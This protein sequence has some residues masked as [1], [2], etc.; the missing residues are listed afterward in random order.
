MQESTVD[1]AAIQQDLGVG[2]LIAMLQ[3]GTLPADL[4]EK[5]LRLFASEVMPFLRDIG[6]DAAVMKEAAGAVA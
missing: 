4:T 3:F 2:N 5:N 1:V 6:N